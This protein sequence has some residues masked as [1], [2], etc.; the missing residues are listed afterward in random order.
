[1][2]WEFQSSQ[3]RN[4]SISTPPPPKKKQKNWIENNSLG[5]TKNVRH[6][7]VTNV[8]KGFGLSEYNLE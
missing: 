3:Q 6:S 7:K 8:A 5:R 2:R 1:M 4:T